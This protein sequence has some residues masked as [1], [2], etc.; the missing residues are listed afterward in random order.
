MKWRPDAST[1]SRHC[2]KAITTSHMKT[3]PPTRLATSVPTQ[4]RSSWAIVPSRAAT[5]A[6]GMRKFSVKSSLWASISAMK[7]ML[8]PMPAS[9]WLPV[10]CRTAEVRH[11]AGAHLEAAEEPGD[12]DVPQAAVAPAARPR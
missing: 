11:H 5:A 6:T 7:P 4:S 1:V 3:Q 9:R 8:K 2:G 12:D 10:S